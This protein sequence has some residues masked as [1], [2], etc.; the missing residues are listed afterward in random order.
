MKFECISVENHLNV[1]SV[2]EQSEKKNK[3]TSVK[4]RIKN[5][6]ENAAVELEKC[7]EGEATRF[8]CCFI[9][10]IDKVEVN[11]T[12][13]FFLFAYMKTNGQTQTKKMY[14]EK[15]RNMKKH[16]ELERFLNSLRE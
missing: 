4:T 3:R 10:R 15:K 13:N 7:R 12:A 14:T 8:F 6:I 1:I 9:L 2:C 5:E 16:I 11:K